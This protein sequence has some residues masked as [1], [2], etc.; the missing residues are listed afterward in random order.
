MK[1]NIKYFINSYV[2]IELEENS[3]A[4]IKF[5]YKNNSEC[6]II[7]KFNNIID[8]ILYERDLFLISDKDTVI[9]IYFSINKTKSKI[10]YF[11]KENKNK[12][13][14]LFNND[15]YFKLSHS[16]DISYENYYSFNSLKL[17]D[18]TSII[19]IEQPFQ[20]DILN[21]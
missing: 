13:L 21:K 7:N 9:Y 19:E 1:S 20:Y 12:K 2:K 18:L 6:C 17:Q 5:L 10:F 11:N 14:I 8:N 15:C 4:S 16:L 3:D